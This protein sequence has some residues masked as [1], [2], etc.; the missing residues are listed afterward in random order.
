MA[1][2]GV[3]SGGGWIRAR[4]QQE[5]DPHHADILEEGASQDHGGIE[6]DPMLR[7]V[8]DSLRLAGSSGGS[9][10]WDRG[11]E[12]QDAAEDA[13]EWPGCR[14]IALALSA[15]GF[16]GVDHE[17]PISSIVVDICQ[18]SFLNGHRGLDLE[19]A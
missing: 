17:H 13:A 9:G 2:S 3:R 6:G 8:K 19:M 15:L 10:F 12:S 11:L 1:A 16:S 14:G 7:L 4:S 18:P 5:I